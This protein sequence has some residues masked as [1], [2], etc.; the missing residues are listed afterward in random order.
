MNQRSHLYKDYINL[1]IYQDQVSYQNFKSI[2]Y[3]ISSP[4][5][6]KILEIWSYDQ[7]HQDI[8]VFRNLMTHIVCRHY[9]HLT[10]V[11]FL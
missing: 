10:Y 3:I 6:K 1:Y 8:F 11:E 2:T 4:N 5:D 9:V 7:C